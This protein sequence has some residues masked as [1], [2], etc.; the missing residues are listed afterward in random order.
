[1]T[2]LPLAAFLLEMDVVHPFSPPSPTFPL[3]LPLPSGLWRSPGATPRAGYEGTRFISIVECV[4]CLWT[5]PF[6]SLVPRI[7]TSSM[8]EVLD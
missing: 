4:V 8:E 1:M 5:C 7:F 6:P 2:S 3:L